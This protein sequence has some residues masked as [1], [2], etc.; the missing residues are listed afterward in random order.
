MISNLDGTVHP[1]ISDSVHPTAGDL[2]LGFSSSFRFG[3]SNVPDVAQDGKDHRVDE[4]EL[5]FTPAIVS[6]GGRSCW[7]RRSSP[8]SGQTMRLGEVTRHSESRLACSV[9]AGEPPR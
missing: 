3:L 2:A 7:H 6:R 1:N 9:I 5:L 8:L 4:L